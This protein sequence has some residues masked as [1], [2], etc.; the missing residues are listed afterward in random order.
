MVV[1]RQVHL[2]RTFYERFWGWMGRKI[3]GEEE[4]LVLIPCRA[5]HTCFLKFPLDVLFVASDGQVLLTLTGLRPF[6]FSPY[7][8]HAQL[9]V[10]LPADRLAQTNTTIGDRLVFYHG[11]ETGCLKDQL[12]GKC[13]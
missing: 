12:L 4:A 3:I 6:R 7:V 11:E 9:V 5:I 8:R 2:A 13:L 10:E 1:A